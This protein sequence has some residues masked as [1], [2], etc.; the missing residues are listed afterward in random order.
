MIR[1]IQNFFFGT[2]AFLAVMVIVSFFWPTKYT[3]E[4]SIHINANIETVFQQVNDLNRWQHWSFFAQDGNWSPSF[5]KWTSGKDA[6]MRWESQR[7]G[8]GDLT[9]LESIPNKEVHVFFE[10]EQVNKSGNASYFFTEKNDGTV[11]THRLELPV[12]LTITDK[13]ENM[14]KY[15]FQDDEKKEEKN[16]QLGYNLNHLKG[17]SEKVYKGILN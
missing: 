9:I 11:V 8:K 5:G 2:I 1:I 13:F 4:E 3:V 12:P 14:S 10:L 7:L 16:L 15:F 6:A 17:V